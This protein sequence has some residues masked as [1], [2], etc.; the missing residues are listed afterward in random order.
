M[1]VKNLSRISNYLRPLP[2]I[3]KSF[4]NHLVQIAYLWTISTYKVTVSI[5]YLTIPM[6]G[7]LK[8]L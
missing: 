3:T 2:T 4:H 1:F 5:M 7:V 8:Y 6:K